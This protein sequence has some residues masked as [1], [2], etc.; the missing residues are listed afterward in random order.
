[1]SSSKG[2]E[3]ITDGAAAIMSPALATP[4]REAE[5]SL[6]FRPHLLLL[7]FGIA[8]LT[9][10]GCLGLF[11]N[12]DLLWGS[13]TGDPL[14]SI[15]MLIPPASVLLTLRVWRQNGWEM[16]GS[17]WGLLVIGLSFSL[18]L[19]QGNA[20][21][22][23]AAFGGSEV[24]L[25]PIS[26]PL[27]VYASG[28][29][30]LFAGTRVWSKAWFPL[31]LLLLS[32]PVPFFSARLIDLPLQ[33]ISAQVA[34]SFATAIGFAPS[35]PQLRLMFSPDFG[36]FIAPGCDG[37]RGAVTMGYVALVLG[38][39]KR[40][41]FR[42]WAAYVA[43]AVLLGYLFNFMR[44]C[45]LVVYYRIALGHPALEGFAKWADY[46]IGA[47]LFLVATLLFLQIMR[48]K[49]DEPAAATIAPTAAK[50]SP[51]MRNLWLRCAALAVVV[52]AAL[53][54]PTSAV[55]AARNSSATP[56]SLAAA[57]PK[58]IGGYDLTRTW[59]EQQSGITVVESG[60]YSAPGSDEITL[61][62]WVAPLFHTHDAAD[63]WLARGLKPDLLVARQFVTANGKLVPLNTGFYSDG[64]TD[65]IVVNAI[66]T[67]TS[68]SQFQPLASK[69][70][71]EILLLKPRIDDV[72]G[73]GAHSVSIMVRIDRPHDKS[74]KAVTDE[75]LTSEVQEFLAGLDLNSLSRTFQ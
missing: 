50:A 72:A 2:L 12:I 66:C 43:G 39:L 13:W 48:R 26:L 51:G 44:L 65:S 11:R 29:V 10:V 47:C 56:T 34:R 68:C 20:R 5:S 27:Y 1:M 8:L 69:G 30:L 40:V 45:I 60:N 36:M 41:S 37:I 17:W 21:V 18:S 75:R 22:V 73:F 63:C 32:Q 61:G 14:R 71:I 58:Q 42:R 38:Y 9:A 33:S 64:V 28:I 24:S 62:V 3:E 16:R 70:K 15:G 23:V 52:L 31:G 35:T 54:M 49:K 57:M 7:W 55:R 46:I 19:L 74:P 6:Q 25:F 4:A 59:Y 53:S 67:P